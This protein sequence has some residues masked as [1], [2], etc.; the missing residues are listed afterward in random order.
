MDFRV[1]MVEMEVTV[2]MTEAEPLVT[3]I[4]LSPYS[5]RH[6]GFETVDEY[7]NGPRAFFPMKMGGVSKLVNRD[8][9]LWLRAPR[10]PEEIAYAAA[11]ADVILEM[12]DGMRVEGMFEITRPVGQA[13]ISD[14]LNHGHELFVCLRD[15]DENYYV[16]KRFIRQVILR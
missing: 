9:I 8:Q 1:P 10:Y 6:G 13:R 15:G 7:L 2:A 14:V 5:H 4:Y 3:V 16:N 11:A 12:I